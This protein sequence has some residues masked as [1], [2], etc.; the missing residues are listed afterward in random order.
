MSD[1]NDYISDPADKRLRYLIGRL[2]M[3]ADT[4]MLSVDGARIEELCHLILHDLHS[5]W[6]AFSAE[7]IANEAVRMIEAK[8]PLV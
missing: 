7:D 2:A 6:G 4:A 1:P 8:A 3:H 5:A